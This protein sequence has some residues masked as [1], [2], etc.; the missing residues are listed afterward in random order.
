MLLLRTVLHHLLQEFDDDLGGRAHQHL[1]LAALLG[2]EDAAQAVVQHGDAHHPARRGAIGRL[3]LTS[4]APAAAAEATG[5]GDWPAGDTGFEARASSLACGAL[6]WR[7]FRLQTRTNG[8][9]AL[10][11]SRRSGRRVCAQQAISG[12]MTSGVRSRYNI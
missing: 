3:S 9:G 4:L 12:E 1:A 6:R 11:R 7:I 5:E 8:E 2:I 10:E